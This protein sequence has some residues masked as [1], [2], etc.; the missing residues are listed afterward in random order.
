MTKAEVRAIT[1]S[2]LALDDQDILLDVGAGTGSISIECAY[3]AKEVY[4]L[5]RNP[6]GIFLIEENKK[7]FNLDNVHVIEGYAP[8]AIPKKPFTKA[9][10]GGTGGQM[11]EVINHL[12]SMDVK[13]IVINTITVENTYKGLEALKAN[14]YGAE[15]VQVSIAKSKGIGGVTM[16][17]GQNPIFILTGEKNED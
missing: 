17:M 11:A 10:V 15:V 12:T 14:G 4:A 8:E 1:L 13:I 5:E 3:F 16:M 7:H 2:K 9:V 6:D